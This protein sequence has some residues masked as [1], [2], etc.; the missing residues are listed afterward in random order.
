[1]PLNIDLWFW[2]L[3]QPP[4]RVDQLAAHLSADE[5]AR[6]A[7][8]IHDI[9]RDQY[10]AGRGRLREIL[11]DYAGDNPANLRFDYRKEGK[12]SL[13]LGPAFNLSHS[14][15]WAALAVGQDVPI[16]IDIE[17]FRPVDEG[18]ARRFFSAREYADLSALPKAQ[19][20]AGFFNCWTRKEAVIKAIGL[21]L[22]MPLDSFDVTLA[23]AK[24]V[25]LTRLEGQPTQAADWSLQAFDAGPNIACAL[26]VYARGAP[27]VTT[28]RQGS[29][30]L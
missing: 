9:H 25:R 5:T 12:P 17:A 2:S 11:A 24:T 19:W 15:G 16:G 3:D 27:V 28:I 6:A 18:I 23:P 13:P 10:L 21:G 4:D 20:E 26:A 7:R 30:P 22:S 29:L 1:M 8:F 14:G